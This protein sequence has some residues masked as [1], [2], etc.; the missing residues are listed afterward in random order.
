MDLHIFQRNSREKVRGRVERG[1]ER[2]VTERDRDR[3][4]VQ[5]ETASLAAGMRASKS[6]SFPSWGVFFFFFPPWAFPFFI[7]V[8]TSPSCGS[9]ENHTCFLLFSGFPN[10]W[11]LKAGGPGGGSWVKPGAGRLVHTDHLLL[12]QVS[13]KQKE[14]A[15]LSHHWRKK[16][17][18]NECH[19]LMGRLPKGFFGGVGGGRGLIWGQASRRENDRSLLLKF[20]RVFPLCSLILFYF[21]VF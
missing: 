17:S 16:S 7:C 10:W 9:S 6:C 4:T 2:T 5:T 8:H 1:R 14:S 3:E 11:T 13:C 19:I 12:F 20:L 15:S 21:F 18:R